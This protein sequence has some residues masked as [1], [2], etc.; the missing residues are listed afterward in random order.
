M[1]RSLGM[2]VFSL[3]NAAFIS[4]SVA[5]A[6]YI[7]RGTVTVEHATDWVGVTLG[8]LSAGVTDTGII[9]MAEQT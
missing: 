3:T 4:V 2:V 1:Y 9:S 6:A 7:S 8:A 5:S